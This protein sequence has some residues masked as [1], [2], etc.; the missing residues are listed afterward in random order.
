MK[1][2]L[3]LFFSYILN[4]VRGEP[5]F[6]NPCLDSVCL[7]QTVTYKCESGSPFLL[8]WRVLDTNGRQYALTVAYIDGNSISRIDPIG[9]E[10]TTVLINT[11]GVIV[12]TIT[13]TAVININNYLIECGPDFITLVNCSIVIPDI[14]PAP[15]ANPLTFGSTHFTF[16]WS[17]STGQCFTNYTV[18]ITS[19][20]SNVTYV[21]NDTSLVI[22]I[23]KS[24]NDTEYSVSIGAVD[25]GG[26]YMS[27]AVIRFIPNAPLSVT[28]LMLTQTDYPTDT[29]E[30][31]NIIVSWNEP[32]SSSRPPITQYNVKYNI[33]NGLQIIPTNVTSQTLSGFSVG[34]VY[35][36]SVEAVNV[37]GTG[38]VTLATITIVL[39]SPPPPEIS[40]TSTSMSPSNSGII[41]STPSM[42]PSNTPTQEPS[43]L[44]AGAIAGIVIVTIGLALAVSVI[45][46]IAIVCYVKKKNE[47]TKSSVPPQMIEAYNYAQVDYSAKSSSSTIQAPPKPAKA[48]SPEA[49]N[50]VLY[51]AIQKSAASHNPPP[52]PEG[53][54]YADLDHNSSS[55]GRRHQRPK[56]TSNQVTYSHVTHHHDRR[57]VRG[58]NHGNY[59]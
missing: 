45:L 37:L 18:S 55:S 11:T 44:S 21:T 38:T 12:S 22:P 28:N 1:L 7:S 9:N 47:D 10:F 41:S 2:V 32:Q 36:V 30:T 33:S 17:P 19:S 8:R 52:P 58:S 46:V 13:F 25:T 51:S 29:N 27:S 16:S 39:A 3:I 15:V 26:R 6:L 59:Y 50:H 23:S 14:L 35:T 24:F 56:D 49:D 57:R 40:S 31:V 53:T 4:L 20:V 34:L 42:T 54:E 43:R 48:I 5:R